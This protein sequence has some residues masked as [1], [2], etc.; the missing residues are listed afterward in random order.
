MVRGALSS[1]RKTGALGSPEPQR[2]KLR[3]PA[4]RGARFRFLIL[5]SSLP[6]L[7]VASFRCMNANLA[8]STPEVPPADSCTY[9]N[10]W[11]DPDDS[12]DDPISAFDQRTRTEGMV[13]AISS[14]RRHDFWRVEHREDAYWLFQTSAWT[15]E[16]G[17]TNLLF[18]LTPELKLAHH[19]FVVMMDDP[20]FPYSG[21][22]GAGWKV[23]L[24][25]RDLRRFH[26]SI[27]DGMQSISQR[28]SGNL[29]ALCE[30]RE[31]LVREGLSDIEELRKQLVEQ[32]RRLR[33]MHAADQRRRLRIEVEPDPETREN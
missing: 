11:V 15:D 21:S 1:G 5:W 16:V 30:A 27:D 20:T 33:R 26:S 28:E 19:I 32:M 6:F 22:L 18:S 17:N 8:F 7:G 25:G 31:R 29:L 9:R 10:V 13:R 23:V 3:P 24:P 4:R 12:R 2:G 14:L